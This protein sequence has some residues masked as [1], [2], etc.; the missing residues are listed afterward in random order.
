MNNNQL[1]NI[2]QHKNYLP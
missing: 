1:F 2:H